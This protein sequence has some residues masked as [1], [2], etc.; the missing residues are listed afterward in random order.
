MN[1]TVTLLELLPC[2]PEIVLTGWYYET[3]AEQQNLPISLTE[4][5]S[6]GLIK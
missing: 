5:H 6:D 1:Q 2:I 4:R 3:Q